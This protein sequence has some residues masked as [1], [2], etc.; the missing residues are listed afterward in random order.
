MRSP[1]MRFPILH[2]GT[3]ARPGRWGNRSK[4]LHGDRGFLRLEIVTVPAAP[5]TAAVRAFFRVNGMFPPVRPRFDVGFHTLE[6]I[7]TAAKALDAL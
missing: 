7:S 6:P 4:A 3:L 1:T 5:M 2:Q